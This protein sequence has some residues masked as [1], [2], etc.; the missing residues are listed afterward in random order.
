M[1]QLLHLHVSKV[2][3]G[4]HMGCAWEAAGCASDVRGS[5]GLLLG[6]SLASPTRWCAHSLS[7]YRPMLV[8][9][10]GCPDTRKSDKEIGM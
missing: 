3:Q 7:G 10:I 1:L 9:Q 8:P 2:D 5:A 4:L 6:H